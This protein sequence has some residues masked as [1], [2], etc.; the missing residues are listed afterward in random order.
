MGYAAPILLSEHQ[1]KSLL[2]LLCPTLCRPVKRAVQRELETSLAKALL[3]GD[4]VEEDTI[5]VSS[6]QTGLVLKKG[7]PRS[8]TGLLAAPQVAAAGRK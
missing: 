6:D 1:A 5:L 8:D 7:P 2:S 4:F 3:R